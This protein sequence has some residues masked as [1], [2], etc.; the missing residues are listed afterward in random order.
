MEQTLTKKV[1]LKLNYLQKIKI[2]TLSNEHRI[3]YNH[4]LDYCRKMWYSGKGADFKGINKEYKKFKEE[5]CLTINSK[6]AQNTSRILINNIKSF[7]NLRKKEINNAKFPGKFK[8]YKI[9]CTFM[10]DLNLKIIFYLYY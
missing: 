10:L 2:E 7:Y 3:L 9:F 6:S 8:S 5:K 1:K 4:L